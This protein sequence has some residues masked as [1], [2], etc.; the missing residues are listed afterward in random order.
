MNATPLPVLPSIRITQLEIRERPTRFSDNYG[1]SEG[2][3]TIVAAVPSRDAP[4]HEIEIRF[5]ASLPGPWNLMHEA[6]RSSWL[7]SQLMAFVAHE[8]DEMLFIAGLGKD[9]HA[10][11]PPYTF[12]PG[13]LLD[14]KVAP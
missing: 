6:A 3:L 2:D 7:R 9:P 11:K 12:A 5:G 10:P 1:L 13:T 4:E 8:I 14:G